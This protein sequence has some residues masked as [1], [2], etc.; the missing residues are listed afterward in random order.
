MRYLSAGESHG[1]ELTAIIEG[2]PANFTVNLDEINFQLSRR[3]KGHGRGGR[4]KIEK[5]QALVTSGIRFNRTTG[6]PICLKVINRDWVNW[7]DKMAHFGEPLE[8]IELVSRPRPGHADLSGGIKYQQ[9]DLRNI[10]ERAS[11]RETTIRVAVGGLARQILEQ[12]GIKIYSHVLQIGSVKEE[13]PVRPF[14]AKDTAEWANKVEESPVR[15]YNSNTEKRMMDEIDKIKAEGDSVGGIIEIIITGAPV[16]L[17]SYVHWE[18]KLDSKLATAVMSVQAIKAVEFGLGFKVGERPG[19][20]VHD[21][22]YH[23]EEAGFYRNTN[24]AGGIEGG[25]TN[26]EPI[27]IRAAMKPIPTLYKPLESVDI[28]T[29]Q[30]FEASIE[31]SD[32]CAVPA[33]AVVVE[34]AVAWELANCFLDKFSGDSVEEI[35]QQVAAYQDLI[36]NY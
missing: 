34:N 1:P 21:A 25:M 31:R 28:E 16:G 24:H 20:Q 27:I 14:E 12:F 5:D 4:M 2:M 9:R 22:I 15:S 35:K 17:G 8:N 36:D 7:E 11:A 3:Q 33:A 26:G 30:A 19:S 29:K 13:N 18:H 6:A 32:A 10:L 23:S